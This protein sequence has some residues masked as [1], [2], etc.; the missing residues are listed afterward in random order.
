MLRWETTTNETTGI[1]YGGIMRPEGAD[2]LPGVAVIEGLIEAV[3]ETFVVK[4]FAQKAEGSGLHGLGLDLL[5]EI[6][7]DKNDRHA[8]AVGDQAVLQ[9]DSAHAGH[10]Q[11]GNQAGRTPPMVGLQVFF[12]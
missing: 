7:G 6:R 3:D 10:M 4:R 2:L 1:L 11:I 12:G 9:V 8:A 5:L